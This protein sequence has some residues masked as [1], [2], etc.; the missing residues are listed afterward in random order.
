MLPS[1]TANDESLGLRVRAGEC[2]ILWLRWSSW[3]PVIY[4]SHELIHFLLEL[5]MIQDLLLI[6]AAL[7]LLLLLL[8]LQC[9]LGL[10]YCILALLSNIAHGCLHGLLQLFKFDSLIKNGIVNVLAHLPQSFNLLSCQTLPK[11]FKTT[12][13][14][15][16]LALWHAF[17]EF[18][19]Q[20]YSLVID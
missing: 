13:L 17:K 3:R 8:V 19:G 14:S 4:R 10:L 1:I 5:R 16:A 7:A 20:S 18:F 12:T 11:D 15:L 2:S 9:S 6:L